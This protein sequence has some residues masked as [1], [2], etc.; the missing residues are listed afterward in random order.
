MK[1]LLTL[2]IVS[3]SFINFISYAQM[4]NRYYFLDSY[5]IDESGS[6][7][8]ANRN[9]GYNAFSY[10]SSPYLKWEGGIYLPFFSGS[11]F[12]DGIYWIGTT[13]NLMPEK[14][15]QPGLRIHFAHFLNGFRKCMLCEPFWPNV[16]AGGGFTFH[17]KQFH[18]T[19]EIALQK[20][21]KS[22]LIAPI[23]SAG[24]LSC[25]GHRWNFWTEVRYTSCMLCQL[26]KSYLDFNTG[27]SY[28]LSEKWIL[29]LGI[30]YENN[31]Y[32]QLVIRFKKFD[33]GYIY[34]LIGLQW[35]ISKPQARENKTDP[36]YERR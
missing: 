5:N 2:I 11:N 20:I 12:L 9:L 32:Q 35:Q 36:F 3:C 31:L 26:D 7:Y 17:T 18:F 21:L 15:W 1:K 24:F 16:Y 8:Y 13:I 30:S 22:D 23:Y 27:I 14:K 33:T 10:S 34:P 6:W 4:P 28:A 25:L 29:N 19:L